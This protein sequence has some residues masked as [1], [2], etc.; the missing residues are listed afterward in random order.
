MWA[1][2]KGPPRKLA[3]RNEV[4]NN[5]FLPPHAFA[6]AGTSINTLATRVPI[7]AAFLTVDDRHRCG[8]C[9]QRGPGLNDPAT[10]G[11]R[12]E[13]PSR[14]AKPASGRVSMP[15]A[16]EGDSPETRCRSAS[17]QPRRVSPGHM[18]SGRKAGFRRHGWQG[19]PWR[20]QEIYRARTIRAACLV[21]MA[22]TWLRSAPRAMRTPISFRRCATDTRLRHKDQPPRGRQ[23]ANRRSPRATP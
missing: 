11:S 17:R 2:C 6:A 3:L 20:P 19:E 15:G 5:H 7:G 8:R 12:D 10:L 14:T 23:R 9:A 1:L 22:I 4:R 18:A 21:T 13:P 16:P